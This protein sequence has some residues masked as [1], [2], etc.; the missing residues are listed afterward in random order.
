MNKLHPFINNLLIST[1]LFASTAMAED[2]PWKNEQYTHYSEQEPLSE[3]LQAM[4]SA[5]NTTAVISG[6]V[7]DI[8]SVYY[9]KMSPERILNQLSKAHD[10]MWFY[11][12]EA[13]FVYKKDE[14]QTGSVTLKHMPVS[15]FTSTMKKLGILDKKFYWKELEEESLVQFKGP[16]RF[17]TS[18]L[19]MANIVDVPRTSHQK[20][21][22]WIDRNGVVNFSSRNPNKGRTDSS[23]S[24]TVLTKD[25]LYAE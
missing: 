2:L 25:N 8:V 7:D 16:E 5:Q 21:Y 3:M 6:Q 19:Q 12:G 15:E 1:L 14:A 22:K 24:V 9:R 20:V 4:A 13:L 23:T 11:D 18:V 17:V 10:L